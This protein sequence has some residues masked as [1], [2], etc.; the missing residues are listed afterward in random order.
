MKP[1]HPILVHFSIALLV[2]SVAADLGGFFT[3]QASLRDVGW[4]ALLAA[5]FGGVVTVAAGV[6]DMRRA[7]LQ[8]ATHHRVHRHMRVGFVLL[9]AIIGLMLWRWRLFV[10]PPAAVPMYLP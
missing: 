6:F 1:I 8:E 2:F 4:W 5:A 7:E 3:G 10:A 9:A